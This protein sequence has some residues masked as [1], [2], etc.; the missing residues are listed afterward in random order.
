VK[1]YT[2]ASGGLVS[3]DTGILCRYQPQPT[4]TLMVSRRTTAGWMQMVHVVRHA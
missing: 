4:A 3:L 1:Y 2:N